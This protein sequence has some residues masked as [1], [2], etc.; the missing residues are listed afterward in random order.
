MKTVLILGA[1]GLIGAHVTRSLRDLGHNVIGLGRDADIAKRVLPGI[2]WIIRDLRNL[3]SAPAWG[4][5]LSGVDFV[6]NCA[7]ALQDNSDDDL[8]AVHA[9]A[10]AAMVQACEVRGCGVI[11]ISAVGAD[12]DAKIAFLKTK[13]QG[14]AAV[15]KSSGK[16]WIFKPGMVVAP[17]GYGGTALV[18]MLAAVPGVQPIALPQA[19][20]QTV[21]VDDVARA[22][23]R[24]ISG[25]VPSGTI[26]DLVEDEPQALANLIT[27][28]RAWFGF[29]KA[30]MTLRLPKPVAFIGAAV[31][32]G[33]GYLGWR[34]PMRRTALKVLAQGV[35]GDAG[36]TRVAL[37]RSAR[38]LQQ[39][40]VT[41]PARLED[42]HTARMM[43]L[44]PG[45]IKTLAGFWIISG[46]VGI[47]QLDAAAQTL[48]QVGWPPVLAKISVG[49]WSCVDIALGVFI[50]F[51]AYAARA[52]WAMILVCLIYLVSATLFTPHMWI[53]PLG[54]LVKIFPA[55]TLAFV[56]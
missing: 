12:A 35:T 24:A 3:Q 55:L 51:R 46:L 31:A 2:G 5:I 6:V 53:D 10:I 28:F 37:G 41:Y 33:L 27:A 18:R 42:R 20:V 25:E 47:V 1:Y 21:G 45:V 52:A 22:V 49:I 14:D 32:D 17:T 11:Q 8:D 4:H 36:Q 30:R 48:V 34:S 43:L 54:P 13:A 15:Q 26:A 19:Q 39:N 44:L 29:P 38:T 40:L 7:G 16:W 23:A 9:K 50:C 56:A